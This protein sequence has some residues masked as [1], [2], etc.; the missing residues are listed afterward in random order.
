MR[1]LGEHFFTKVFVAFGIFISIISLAFTSFFIQ[2]QS[3]TLTDTLATKGR[4]L[5]E[6]LAHNTRL[7]IFFE[8][9]EQLQDHME[10]ILR[11]VGVK[12]AYIYNL[13]GELLLSLQRRDKGGQPARRAPIRQDRV[14]DENSI[15]KLRARKSTLWEQ[16]DDGFEF[17][18]A[19]ISGPSHY[20]DASMF[21]DEY[22][23]KQVQRVIGFVMIMID[24]ES[25]DSRINAL[26]L[27]G[28]LIAFIFL[29]GGFVATFFMVKGIT[30]PLNRLIA[31]VIS[32]GK[33]GVAEAVPVQTSDEIGQLAQAFN[34][35]SASLMTRE[36]SLRDSEKRLRLLSAKLLEVQE[37]ERRRISRELHDE[38]GQGLAILKHRLG[39]IGR[40]LSDD[41]EDLFEECNETR[42]YL[43]LIIEDVR[44]LSR[45]L[46]PNIL[47][48]LGLTAAL[49]WLLNAF[50]EN[51][52][53]DTTVD[54]E[55]VDSLF[56][57][58]EQT[59]LYRISQESLTNISKHARARNVSF[60]VENLGET[61][62][63]HVR[64]DGMGFDRKELEARSFSEKGM[65]LEAMHERAYMLKGSLDIHSR[66]GEGTRILLTVP[67]ER[68]EDE[69]G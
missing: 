44:R 22:P 48:D 16:V 52:E 26:L 38:L 57:L 33:D 27:K 36:R 51:R 35:M 18:A 40:G 19:V 65:G 25:L 13:E 5:S 58:N 66:K 34:T 17:W 55:N 60:R 3:T 50:S 20:A 32:L 59:N 49:R 11:Q 2:Q 39:S 24:R 47:T 9:N 4:L 23:V 30:R 53:I 62:R 41:Q 15:F 42:E 28:I 64:D 31:G 68:G 43:G 54:I 7:G 1:K 29:A 8:N 37:L 12:Y 10:G 61:I 46:S 67:S 14:K 45:D 6:I 21:F 56:N 69:D 63:F